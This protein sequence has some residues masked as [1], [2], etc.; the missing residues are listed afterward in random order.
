[1]NR[2]SSIFKCHRCG[3]KN[4]VPKD[5]IGEKP[6]CGKCKAPLSI[7]TDA[8]KPIDVTDKTFHS[9]ILAFP[10]PALVD[11]WAPW[12]GPCRTVGPV[13]EQLASE[14]AG[15]VKIVKLNVDEN[16]QTAARYSIRSIPTMLLFN[17][18]DLVNTLV[19][20]LPKGEIASHL[21]SLLN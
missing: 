14:Y 18:G 17:Q 20:A 5:R 7:G 4:R 6:V 15:R 8:H 9:E 13:I 21:N 2:E 11:C 3:T 12:C 1:M 16:Q 10:G 19:G